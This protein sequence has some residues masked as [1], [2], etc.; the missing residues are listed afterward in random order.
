MLKVGLKTLAP[1]ALAVTGAPQGHTQKKK[2]R[3]TSA[4]TQL[5]RLTTMTMSNDFAIQTKGLNKVYLSG[6]WNRKFVGLKDL[7]LTV[8][9]GEVFGFV[10]PNGAGKTTTM[11]ILVG[12]QSATKGEASIFG[13]DHRNPESKRS[14]GFLPERPYF[15][16][17]LS[18]RE[19]LRFYGR[20]FNMGGSALEARINELIERVDLVKF[21]DLPLRSY[22]KGML[23]RAGI[24]QALIN[25]PE[26]I[27]LDE[28]MS[29]LDPMGRKLIRDVI[30]EESERGCTIFFSS[31]ILTDV[32]QICDRIGLIVRGELRAVGSMEQL[33]GDDV[34]AVEATFD[35]PIGKDLGLKQDSI[36]SKRDRDDGSQRLNVTLNKGQVSEVLRD[37]LGAGG[38][39]IRVE[40]TKK[41]LET[42]LSE[43]IGEAQQEIRESTI[44][45]L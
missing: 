19:L 7:D 20:L 18:A 24:A 27:I 2:P 42:V 14:V 3:N 32:E 43:K 28:P 10:G 37:V 41:S 12:L 15:Y 36:T 39:V 22:S 25:R 34:K 35:I 26:L 4:N 33:I 6:F 8:N 30:F 11:K 16:S 40:P 13:I 23:Q 17:H 45:V 38:T 29:G 31:H 5:S 44:G 1:F 21:A 9:R